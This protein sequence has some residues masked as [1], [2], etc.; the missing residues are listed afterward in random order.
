MGTCGALGNCK[1]GD[2]EENEKEDEG[3]EDAVLAESHPEPVLK[4]KC[5]LIHI[6]DGGGLVVILTKGGFQEGVLQREGFKFEEEMVKS[7]GTPKN[8]VS[9][10]SLKLADSGSQ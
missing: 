4:A 7:R 5:L 10:S 8:D 3:G 9:T 2:C 1:G 6:D